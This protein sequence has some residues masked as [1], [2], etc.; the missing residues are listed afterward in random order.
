MVTPIS[1]TICTAVRDL[2]RSRRVGGDGVETD[3]MLSPRVQCIRKISVDVFRSNYSHMQ[4]LDTFCMRKSQ[5][6]IVTSQGIEEGAS[7]YASIKMLPD[8]RHIKYVR[9][10]GRVHN[11]LE[12]TVETRL[13]VGP[14]GLEILTRCCKL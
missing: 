14:D 7:I 3:V 2:D 4:G 6:A 12:N 11:V 9:T 10:L 8:R 5:F 13:R 1:L